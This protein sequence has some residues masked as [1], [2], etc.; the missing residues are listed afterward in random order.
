MPPSQQAGLGMACSLPQELEKQ[1][2]GGYG[3][4]PQRRPPL[5]NRPAQ[6][7]PVAGPQSTPQMMHGKEQGCRQQCTCSVL[8]LHC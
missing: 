7:A 8:K 1:G 4:D 6:F 5:P 3:D 2:A